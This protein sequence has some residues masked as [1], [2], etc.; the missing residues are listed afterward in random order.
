MSILLAGILVLGAC[1]CAELGEKR[2][3]AFFDCFD[4]VITLTAYG[5]TEHEFELASA[6]VEAAFAEYHKLYDVYNRYEGVSNLAVVNDMAGRSVAVDTRILD[7]LEFGIAAHELTD[8]NVNIAMGAVLRLWH[9]CRTAAEADPSNA[10]IP[11]EDALRS[12]ALHCN[13]TDV[14]ID[15]TNSTVTLL[16]PHMSLDVGAI[17]KG[18]ACERVAELLR[19]YDGSYMLNC[20]GAVR[21]LSEKPGGSPWTIGIADPNSDSEYAARVELTDAALSTSGSYIRYFEVNGERYGHII[22]PE[23]L[24]PA[25]GAASVSV[26]CGDAALADVLSTAC[27]ILTAEEAIRLIESIESAEAL[28]ISEDGEM[29]HTGG[30]PLAD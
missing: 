18:Y 24:M 11:A 19:A 22:D 12:A 28:V 5:A 26:L 4:T 3:A 14:K 25:G 2:S 7:L 23:T 17:A 8:G 1:S 16:D 13:I 30:F 20:G 9:D 29:L 6:A 21:T 27:Y 10:S 15:R